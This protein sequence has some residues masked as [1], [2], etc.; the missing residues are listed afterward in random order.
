MT[1]STGNERSRPPS[2]LRS[3]LP[4]T[5]FVLVAGIVGP[6]FWIVGVNVGDDDPDA[7]WLVPVGVA[8]TVLDLVIG[9]GIGLLKYRGDQKR[10][11]LQ[12]C[13]RWGRAQVL[14]YDETNVQINDEPLIALRLRIHGD[15]ITPFEVECKKVV[16]YGRMSLLQSGEVPVRVDPESRE[17]EFAWSAAQ[18]VKPT[19][20][21]E[22]PSSRTAAERL[23]ELDDL[24]K[25][26]LIGREEYDATRTRILGEL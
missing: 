10:Y 26:D 8:I 3:V 7:A 14:S 12:Q 4:I 1:P 9:V 21:F 25:R 17:W 6:I 16:P 5:L 15:D 20:A 2:L 11:R 23:A 18:A 24:L 13:G 22:P 19:S